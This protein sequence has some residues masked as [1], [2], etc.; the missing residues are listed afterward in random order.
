MLQGEIIQCVFFFMGVIVLYFLFCLLK[1]CFECF[2]FCVAG[3]VFNVCVIGE[4]WRVCVARRVNS[5]CH[6]GSVCMCVLF[7][8]VSSFFFQVLCCKESVLVLSDRGNVTSLCCKVGVSFLWC[9]GGVSF[10]HIF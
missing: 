10:H 5:M 3:R 8:S 6:V 4:M 2:K 1:K 9:K 7:L